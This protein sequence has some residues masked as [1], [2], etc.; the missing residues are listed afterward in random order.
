VALLLWLGGRLWV[1]VPRC[2]LTPRHCAVWG[3]AWWLLLPTALP[4]LLLLLLCGP[5][6]VALV[7]G[8]C[9]PASRL[10]V[11]RPG[12]WWSGRELR[13]Q[14][15]LQQ[16]G[17]AGCQT[18]LQ[19]CCNLLWSDGS[20]CSSTGLLLLLLLLLVERQLMCVL[21]LLISSCCGCWDDWD[22]RHH[23]GC[24]CRCGCSC[25]GLGCYA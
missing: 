6:P 11:T 4:R 17:E 18:R 21:H 24:P 2:S 22:C 25:K 5:W 1:G 23:C 8:W 3:T 14:S 9:T 19:G 13:H 10:P 16:V 20:L 12:L 7:G 15:M